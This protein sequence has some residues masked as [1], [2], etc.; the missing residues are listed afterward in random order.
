[1]RMT[2]QIDLLTEARAVLKQHWGYDDFRPA[3]KEILPDILE[4]KDV[5]VVMP[6]GGGKSVLFQ[7]PALI[8]RG[9]TIVVSPLIALMKDQ[10]D[11]CTRRGISA[12]YVNSHVEPEEVERRF[13]AWAEGAYQLFY[14]APERLRVPSFHRYLPRV[15][16]SRI[17]VDEAH[18]AAQ[19][20]HDFRPMYSRIHDLVR[21]VTQY[22]ERRPSV[23][24]VTATATWDIEGQI[25]AA[26]GMR[27]GYTRY[28]ADPIRPNLS[29]DVF[30][31]V[32]PWNAFDKLVAALDL[33][34]G[35]HL[36][37]CGTQKGAETLARTASNV[38]RKPVQAYHAGMRPEAR[39]EVQEDF[40]AGRLR[41][42]VATTAFGM[43]IDVPD[44]RTVIH[45]GIPDSLE[46]YTQQA[47]R[48]GR[49]GAPARCILLGDDYAV[50]LQ[51]FFVDAQNPPYSAYAEVW[52]W[53]HTQLKDTVEILHMS[54]SSICDA[55]GLD[56]TAKNMPEQQVSTVL[57]TMESHG[58][59]ERHYA[60]EGTP[61]T[62]RVTPLREWAAKAKRETTKR[63]I[64]HLLAVMGV[65]T[66]T[67]AET[68][69]RFV[70]KKKMAAHLRLSG[71]IVQSVLKQ[72]D[73]AGVVDLGDT[74]VGKT[75]RIVKYGAKIADFLPL[76]EIEKKRER[77][78]V[79]LGHMVD[80][81][82]HTTE[83]QRKEHIRSYF[84]GE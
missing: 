42:V 23:L 34:A 46:S 77:A 79:R 48:A 3:Q 40:K 22:N 1:M 19:W 2:E 17:A 7:V 65:G 70:D 83:A 31:R 13:A 74:Y 66:A 10:V 55:L 35:R 14:I 5:L 29:Y 51:R 64:E 60:A 53:L 32:N 30:A 33:N 63:V 50:D 71:T 67:D 61:V 21:R 11:D 8:E 43:G 62:V 73:E 57:N 9:C 59:V 78:L 68:V 27:D 75:T 41:L 26:L 76:D 47:G 45:F 52:D 12:S 20:G 80:Y 6:T 18:C 72:A 16:V 36:V 37:Y 28:V 39:K 24:A 49:D 81:T 38:L 69:S 25:A 82:R 84:L 58:L 4:G 44:I 15:N 56:S 54:A